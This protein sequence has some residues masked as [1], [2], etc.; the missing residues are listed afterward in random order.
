MKKVSYIKPLIYYGIEALTVNQ[1]EIDEL[2]KI[3]GK[4]V[5]DMIGIPNKCR[6][7]PIYVFL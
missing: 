6:T 4:A 3:E 1:I 7:T 5:K 2:K